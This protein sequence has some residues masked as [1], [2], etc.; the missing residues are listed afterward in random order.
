MCTNNISNCKQGNI[1]RDG[2]KSYV[3]KVCLALILAVAMLG[4]TM[5]AMASA[6]TCEHVFDSSQQSRVLQKTT[7]VSYH[8]HTDAATGVTYKCTLYR[9]YYLVT[10]KCVNCGGTI[11]Y[12]ETHEYHQAGW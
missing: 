1:L 11:S 4:S 6:R 10:D 12:T 2:G 5:T 9:A 8:E 7:V 3:R